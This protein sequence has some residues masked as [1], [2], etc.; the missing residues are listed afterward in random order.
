MYIVHMF[1]SSILFIA[2]LVLLIFS[3]CATAPPPPNPQKEEMVRIGKGFGSLRSIGI[4]SVIC[5][6]DFIQNL[7][8]DAESFVVTTS[9]TTEYRDHK[10]LVTAPAKYE[11][12]G[13]DV[14]TADFIAEYRNAMTY[15]DIV[16]SRNPLNYFQNE[17]FKI[18]EAGIETQTNQN[19][20]S[21]TVILDQN[22]K[23]ITI[24]GAKDK[25]RLDYDLVFE[26][27]NLPV[28][29]TLNRITEGKTSEQLK[30]DFSYQDLEGKP[31]LRT[32]EVR[33]MGEDADKLFIR[34]VSN[35]CTLNK[36]SRD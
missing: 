23:F 12:V 6:Q 8:E 13:A 20:E 26:K 33:G 14:M 30:F 28:A 5:E 25:M 24:D 27:H 3:G 15:Y 7:N 21:K 11:G 18:V 10:Y 2:G 31:V 34:I 35:S 4:T 19:G 9:L 22:A 32:V 17:K 36:T 29:M 16:F 1:K